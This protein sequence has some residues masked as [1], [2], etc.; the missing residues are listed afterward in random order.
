MQQAA[1]TAAGATALNCW[2]CGH[3]LPSSPVRGDQGRQFCTQRCRASAL[4]GEQPFR[5]AQGFKR[6]SPGVSV[7]DALLPEGIPANS[8][9]LLD[10]ENGIRHRTLQTELLWRALSRGEP[11]I[12]LTF[13]DPPIAIVEHFL[14]CGWNVLPYLGSGRLRIVDCFTNR[15]RTKH[16]TP[17]YDVAWNEYLAEFLE[18]SVT[19]L[20]ETEDLRAVESKLHSEL[21]AM[22]MHE[23]GI[24][25]IDSINE[26]EFI[27]HE[28]E[29]Q[30]FVKEVRGD[31][32]SRKFVPIIASVTNLEKTQPVNRYAYL[33]DGI[34]EMR[35][36]ESIVEGI[37][38][39]QL[40][41][42]KMDGV[43]YRPHWVSYVMGP[44]GFRLFDPQS[45]LQ[46]VY[47]S[48]WDVRPSQSAPPTN[49]H[50]G[51]SG[52]LPRQTATTER[53]EREPTPPAA[54]H[55]G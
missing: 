47:G 1:T 16:Q 5:N 39:K 44:D 51:A 31:I 8:F 13:V 42:Q 2:F 20:R 9:V 18:D 36:D 10:G 34:V 23:Q 40:S 54:D 49:R 28:F 25:V 26:V 4:R 33:F 7:L 35:R 48:P 46:A 14:Q 12:V 19:R 3:A 29:T 21:E 30:K 6:F 41:I 55:H 15:L 43:F 22:N 52:S 37:R 50:P 38:L 32:C 11:A 27:G 45:E 53:R 24:V 17:D